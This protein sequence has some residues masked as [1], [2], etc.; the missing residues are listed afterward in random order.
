MK[1]L[2]TFLL[3]LCLSISLHAQQLISTEFRGS[4]SL[5]D[6]IDDY[7]PTMQNG[8]DMYKITYTTPDIEGVTDTASGLVIIPVRDEQLAYPLLCFQHSTGIAPFDVPSNLTGGIDAAL[9]FAG[10]GYV[11][12]AADYLGNGEARGLHPYLHAATEA[13]AAIDML[14]A[15]QEMAP[16]MGFHLNDQLFITGNAQ[17]GHAALAAHGE[18]QAAYSGDFTVTASAPM[19]GPYVLST[20]F[21]P[22]IVEDVEFALP[23]F[24][25]F[26]VL[27]Y[28]LAYDLF[29]DVHQ[30]F[31][32]PYATTIQNFLDGTFGGLWANNLLTDQ[33]ITETGASVPSRMFQDSVVS[34]IMSNPSH[35]L[36]LALEANDV[37]DWGPDA[38][39]R[40]FYCTADDQVPYENSTI[41]SST[42][43]MHGAPNVQAVDVA[44]AADHFDCLEP[45]ISAAILFF[46]TYQQLEV[47]DIASI[48]DVARPII[49][50]NPT[51]GTFWVENVPTNAQ[52]ELLDVSGQVIY[53]QIARSD[54]E[55]ILIDGLT[56]G[57][58]LLR[59][60]AIDGGYR[61]VKVVVK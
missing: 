28:D 40:L 16:Q 47:V 10:M 51:S 3:M 54:R 55:E 52:L 45:A 11:I 46:G 30:Y 21:K 17:G 53:Q 4:L 50:P 39:T 12:S 19:S 34:N 7:G 36:N 35:P 22:L 56:S 59:I 9:P 33:L 42:M 60:T 48:A 31:K 5:Q 58:Y 20:V 1:N 24:V 13:S 27:S 38:P 18:L 26:A 25:V 49:L 14:F 61:T 23:F 15:V 44:P 6:M 8:V 29:D 57:L 32:E 37:H 43:N 2:K 41:A